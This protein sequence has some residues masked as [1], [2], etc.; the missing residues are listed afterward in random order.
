MKS[1]KHIARRSLNS[2]SGGGSK[3]VIKQ[4]ADKY[5]LVYFGHVDP[6]ED[7]YELVRG[8]TVS[9][10]HVDNYYTVGS[11]NSH[12]IILVERQ[13]TLTY[14][15]KPDKSYRWLIM[16]IDLKHGD[17]PHTFIDS[18]RHD[19][20]FY[21]NMFMSKHNLQDMTSY[22]SGVSALFAQKCRLFAAPTQYM[23]VGEMLQPNIAE[24]IARH[25]NQFDYEFL[26]D[27]V[28]VYASNRKATLPLLE[29]MLRIGTWLAEEFNSLAQK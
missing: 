2:L 16:Q 13:N 11:H 19:A 6:H 15:N 29:D 26:E 12:D 24:T 22:F 27:R 23:Q 20:V 5:H 18:K 17:L 1:L 28:L 25:F 3:R 8:L 21:A 7:E 10:T 9:T 14:P 4:F